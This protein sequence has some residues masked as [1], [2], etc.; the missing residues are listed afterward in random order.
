MACAILPP[1]LVP[2]S[3]GRGCG[4]GGA[5]DEAVP[6]TGGRGKPLPY[7]MTG[8][9][10][11]S[12]RRAGQCPT[13]TAFLTAPFGSEGTG[14]VSWLRWPSHRPGPKLPRRGGPMWPPACSP[15][16][17]VSPPSR[18][19]GACPSR[20]FP[21]GFH[22]ARRI[23]P[24]GAAHRVI[25]PYGRHGPQR[26]GGS[27][28]PPLRGNYGPAQYD[29]HHSHETAPVP[30]KPNGAAKNAVGADTGPPVLC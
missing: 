4:I 20:W 29:G 11:L 6:K 14:A 27:G 13:S 18:R 2:T 28:D 23:S 17:N 5:P 30:P 8:K 10:I 26:A 24:C 1:R 19:G 7:E 9:A 25:A 16:G 15:P 3:R 12:R 21:E 22:F